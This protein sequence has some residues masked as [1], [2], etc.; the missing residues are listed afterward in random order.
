MGSPILSQSAG[1]WPP[2]F[3]PQIL[4]MVT[5]C[6]PF[7]VLSF[8]F[9]AVAASVL[10]KYEVISH[11]FNYLI[12]AHSIVGESVEGRVERGWGGVVCPNVMSRFQPLVM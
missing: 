6:L 3:N 11:L 12:Y 2:V 1:R 8:F 5:C 7:A 9:S 10:G 4:T